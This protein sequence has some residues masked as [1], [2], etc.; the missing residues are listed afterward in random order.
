MDLTF[1]WY[2]DPDPVGLEK[3]RQIPGLRGLVAALYELGPGEPWTDWRIAARREKIEAAGLEW[4]VVES[5]PVHEEIKYGGPERDTRIEAWIESLHAVARVLGPP[6]APT[7]SEAPVVVTYNFMPV[8]D[9][10]RSDLGKLLPDGSKALAYEEEAVAKMDPLEGELEL[11][12]WLAH[13]SRAELF[14][15]LGRW[16]EVGG[17]ELWKNLGYFLRAVVPVAEE[18]GLR[19]AIHPDDPPWPI[20]GIPRIVTDAAALRRLLALCDSKANSLC[21]CAGSLGVLAGNDLVAMAREF[22]GRT[23]FAHLR[24]VKITGP[25]SFEESAHWSGSGSLDLPALVEALLEGGFEGPYR[26]DHGRMIWGEEGR[27][28]Y[29]LHDRALGSQYLLGLVEATRRG[30]AKR[31]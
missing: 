28:G 23:A 14:R 2:G 19:L 31:R 27:P 24:N 17:E 20:F 26:P 29:G 13:Y 21:L 3:I 6:S 25:R 9:W 11:P 15:L 8:F 18:C 4:R 12:G 22:A 5:I 30:I 16:R 10:T 7:G 1:R